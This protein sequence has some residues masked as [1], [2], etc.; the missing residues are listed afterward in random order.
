[1]SEAVSIE[2]HLK[3]HLDSNLPIEGGEEARVEV[4]AE[5]L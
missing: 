1:M 2:N 4:E 5:H 3:V